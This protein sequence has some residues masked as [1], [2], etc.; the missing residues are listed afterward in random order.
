MC[1][2]PAD[3][4]LL[5]TILLLQKLFLSQPPS[6]LL[7]ILPHLGQVSGQRFLSRLLQRVSELVQ[8]DKAARGRWL[9]TLTACYRSV[10]Q[11]A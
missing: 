7:F 8:G 4:M 5:L 6:R 10:G 11:Q 2:G 9:P 3:T 1:Y